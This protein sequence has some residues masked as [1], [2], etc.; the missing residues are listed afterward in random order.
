MIFG[1]NRAAATTPEPLAK[2]TIPAT[3]PDAAAAT[4]TTA[5]PAMAAPARAFAVPAR[6][7][8]TPPAV[9]PPPT[10]GP[11]AL[12]GHGPSQAIAAQTDDGWFINA[13]NAGL[14]KYQAAQKLTR[15]DRSDDDTTQ[16]VTIH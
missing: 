13:M 14:N 15:N 9:L 3:T 5:A 6:R 16:D 7:N 11:A 4:R 12:P 1:A 8:P 10:T 2:P